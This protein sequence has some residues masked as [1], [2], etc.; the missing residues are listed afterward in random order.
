MHSNEKDWGKMVDTYKEET[1][2]AG[3]G[4]NVGIM[5]LTM[6]GIVAPSTHVRSRAAAAAAE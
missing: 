6:R 2:S 3:G 1:K 5:S 4:S